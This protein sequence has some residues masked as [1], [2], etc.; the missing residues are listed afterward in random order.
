MNKHIYN[1]HT[2]STFLCD[3]EVL[4][5]AQ[6]TFLQQQDIF[7]TLTKYLYS[8]QIFITGV[9]IIFELHMQKY[10]H[11]SMRTKPLYLIDPTDLYFALCF[12]K[13]LNLL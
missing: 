6:N 12:C 3:T 10:F 5:H 8:N 2:F 13:L 11:I 1:G 9:Q 4:T 7:N